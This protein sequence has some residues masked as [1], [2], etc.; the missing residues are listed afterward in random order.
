MMEEMQEKLRSPKW[1]KEMG[2][3]NLGTLL[4]AGILVT[5]VVVAA[6]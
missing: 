3:L 5:L 1:W 6:V 2:M 4:V